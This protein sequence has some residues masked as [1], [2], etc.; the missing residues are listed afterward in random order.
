MTSTVLQINAAT[1]ELD[2]V[3]DV[4]VT[5]IEVDDGGNYVREFR[6]FGALDPGATVAPLTL[7]VRVVSATREAIEVTTPA[8]QM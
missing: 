2:N 5:P 3:Q 1:V 4:V 8:L 7:S 6:F